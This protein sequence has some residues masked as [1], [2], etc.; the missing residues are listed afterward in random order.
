MSDARH[1]GRTAAPP[2]GQPPEQLRYA[3]LLDAGARLGMVVLVASFV[4]YTFGW[5]PPEV[6]LERLPALWSL[7]VGEYLTQTGVATGWGW[8]DRVAHG[9]VAGLLGIAILAAASVPCLLAMLPLALGRGDRPL[10][11]MCVLQVV[12]IVLAASGWLT[13]VH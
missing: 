13:G 12:V 3:R 4:L 9:D 2:P 11:A 7:P 5:L 1:P 8:L 10:A 6:S